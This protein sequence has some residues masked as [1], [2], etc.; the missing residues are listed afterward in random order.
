[1]GRDS[2]PE[3]ESIAGLFANTVPHRFQFAYAQ[4]F[5]ANVARISRELMNDLDHQD[6]PFDKIV[7]NRMG[8]REAGADPLCQVAFVLQNY[9]S[10]SGH[11]GTSDFSPLVLPIAATRYDLSLVAE[12]DDDQYRMT[13]YYR[14][15]ALDPDVATAFCDRFVHVLGI[16]AGKDG[17]PLGQLDILMAREKTRQELSGQ[18]D[19]AHPFDQFR[20]LVATHPN[21]CA[22]VE[23]GSH[24]SYRELMGKTMAIADQLAK[25]EIGQGDTVAIMLPRSCMCVAS[26]LAILA[27][28]AAVLLLDPKLPPKRLDFI[29]NDSD[30]TCV[31][32]TKQVASEVDWQGNEILLLDDLASAVEI[33]DGSRSATDPAYLIYTSGSTGQPKGAVNTLAGLAN[34]LSGIQMLYPIGE[35]DKV[36]HKAPLSFDVAYWEM[37]WPLTC[38]ASLVIAQDGSEA[39]PAA[40]ADLIEAEGVRVAHF[41]PAML[42]AFLASIEPERCSSLDLLFAGGE[43]LPQRLIDTCATHLTTRLVNSYGPSETAIGVTH[44]PATTLARGAHVPI[45]QPMPNVTLRVLDRHHN[46]VPDGVLGELCI[47]GQS[48]GAGYLNRPEQTRASF[49]SLDR[50]PHYLTG[51]LVQRLPNGDV[52]FHG[53]LD[54]QVK[55][56]GQRIEL[57][58]V[59]AALTRFPDILS[60]A[61]LVKRDGDETASARL[62]AAVVMRPGATLDDATLRGELALHLPEVMI[63]T[64]IIAIDPLPVTQNGKT[65]RKALLELFTNATPQA[66]KTDLAKSETE[67]AALFHEM[68]GVTPDSRDADFFRLGGHSL[69]AIQL[70]S[71]IKKAFGVTV[72]LAQFVSNPT[73][74]ALADRIGGQT[75]QTTTC[76]QH[77]RRAQLGD[78]T[79]ILLHPALGQTTCYAPL[80]AALPDHWGV[81]LVEDDG[82][83]GDMPF[84]ERA[85]RH[86]RELKPLF[87]AGPVVLGGWSSGGLLACELER[88]ADEIGLSC[89]HL[90]LI[91]SHIHLGERHSAEA[92]RRGFMRS[93]GLAPRIVKDVLAATRN[94]ADDAALQVL[95][96][97]AGYDVETLHH[98]SSNYSRNAHAARQFGTQPVKT[99]ALCI[100]ATRYSDPAQMRE[101]WNGVLNTGTF[102]ELAEDHESVVETGAVSRIADALMTAI[103]PTAE[104]ARF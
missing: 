14:D 63:P 38:G 17:S 88:A 102:L 4:D 21:A 54:D 78:P 80:A 77:V 59:N 74:G 15:G 104:K 51:D 92:A 32:T 91:D 93:F 43:A 82:T 86:L 83:F 44:W 34:F 31:I 35:G 81:T 67:V 1:A 10:A 69:L 23:D 73:L 24:I 42:S 8:G 39:D 56:G 95:A 94:M 30:A 79:V 27:N 87:D 72:N 101:R 62:V 65:D 100:I 76:Y 97:A 22:I 71:R 55:L 60:A 19:I 45:G 5:R 33:L 68:L 85:K 41:V 49:K 16:V 98:L 50:M 47:A 40:L 20:A 57:D 2:H 26:L 75:A 29:R 70:L 28:G 11:T 84:D 25:R 90:L 89:K 48:V 46:D 103:G 53:R 52:L 64:Q 96:E 61:T 13:L 3:L 99:P 18:M 12:T 6:A 37:L 58:E 7:A 36:L 66:P 9:P